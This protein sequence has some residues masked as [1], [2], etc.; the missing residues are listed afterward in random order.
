MAIITVVLLIVFVICMVAS[1]VILS[2]KKKLSGFKLML[3]GIN[4]TI[5]GGIIAVDCNADLGGMEYLITI[6][7]IVLSLVGFAK[8]DKE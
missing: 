1:I 7:G 8:E 2:L 6:A 5:L 3:L 4:A